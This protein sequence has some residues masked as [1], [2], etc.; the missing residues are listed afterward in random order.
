MKEITI[1]KITLKIFFLL[2]IVIYTMC[3]VVETPEEVKNKPNYTNNIDDETDNEY[4][5]VENNFAT[6]WETNMADYEYENIFTVKLKPRDD[7]VFYEEV[8]YLHIT[9]P[10]KGAYVVNQREEIDAPI[11]LNIFQ[12]NVKI[13]SALGEEKIFSFTVKKEGVIAIQLFNYS[14]EE[15]LLTFTISAGH[16]NPAKKEDIKFA[17]Q[18]I[19]NLLKFVNRFKV[20]KTLLHSKHEDKS[21]QFKQMG[22]LFYTYTMIE[23]AILMLIVIVQFYFIKRLFEVKGS[24]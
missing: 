6:D 13:Y 15:V 9:K 16:E 21:K 4:S 11:L 7:M 18:K 20:E 23:T 1:H 2:S 10:I 24:F 3:D 8:N 14:E 17:D 22:K 19:D 5:Q 12:D